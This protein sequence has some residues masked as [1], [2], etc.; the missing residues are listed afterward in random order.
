MDRL[1]KLLNDDFIKIQFAKNNLI[2]KTKSSFYKN[3]D[4]IKNPELKKLW[5]S[6]ENEDDD[7]EIIS[8]CNM[9]NLIDPEDVDIIYP[10]VGSYTR[11]EKFSKVDEVFKN[12]NQNMGPQMN[13]FF[14]SMLFLW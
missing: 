14:K 11:L 8:I 1:E 2:N 13:F 9:I 7:V 3:T 10:L 4:S 12:L 5:D 6:L